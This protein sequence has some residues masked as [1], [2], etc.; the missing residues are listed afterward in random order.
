MD[1][2]YLF[3]HN[4]KKKRN[5]NQDNTVVPCSDIKTSEIIKHDLVIYCTHGNLQ[6]TY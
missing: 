1:L 3:F 2:F 6:L 5:D 4:Y